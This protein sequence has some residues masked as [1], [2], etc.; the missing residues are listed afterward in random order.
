[1]A[2]F[3]IYKP[4]FYPPAESNSVNQNIENEHPKTKPEPKKTFIFCPL[5]VICACKK[6]K[7]KGDRPEKWG[8]APSPDEIGTRCL[9]PFFRE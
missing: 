7:K 9:S 1:M 2:K 4:A 6:P 8:L 5:A 3:S